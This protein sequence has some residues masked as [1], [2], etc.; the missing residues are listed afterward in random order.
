MRECEREIERQSLGVS[1]DEGLANNLTG[2]NGG[3]HRND[4]RFGT[5][6]KKSL[7]L[8]RAM[9]HWHRICTRWFFA[10]DGTSAVWG[11]PSPL[12]AV[13]IQAR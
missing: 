7:T 5:V 9:E 12:T 2:Q 10:G 11:L 4:E 3:S 6:E 1:G 13:E 8:A